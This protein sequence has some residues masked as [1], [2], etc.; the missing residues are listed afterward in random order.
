MRSVCSPRP[1]L[2]LCVVSAALALAGCAESGDPAPPPPAVRSEPAPAPRPAVRPG[3][4]LDRLLAVHD[5]PAA[6]LETLRPPRSVRAE[7]VENEYIAGQT[8]TVRTR[9]YDGLRL[10]TYEVTDGPVFVQSVTVTGTGYGTSGGA[11][12]GETRAALEAVLGPPITGPDAGRA[13]A[14]VYQTGSGPAPT[15]VEVTYEPDAGGTER[16]SE[17]VWRPYLD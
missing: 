11:A 7:P 16:A 17:I 12:V 14:V 9:V 8:D 1:A 5:D 10:R 3:V 2:R 15:T 13:G 4:S 6:F